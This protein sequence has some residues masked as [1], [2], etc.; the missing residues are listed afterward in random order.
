[1]RSKLLQRNGANRIQ[2]SAESDCRNRVEKGTMLPA[3]LPLA[4]T[5][6]QTH[7][8]GAAPVHTGEGPRKPD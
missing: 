7:R 5:L 1:M 8:N 2:E 4:G 3:G 6:L